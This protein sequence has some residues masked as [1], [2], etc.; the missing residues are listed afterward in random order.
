VCTTAQTPRA[1]PVTIVNTVTTIKT[2]EFSPLKRAALA[3]PTCPLCH[4]EDTT[5]TVQAV[6]EGGTWRCTRCGQMWSAD[7]LAAVAAYADK[8]FGVNAQVS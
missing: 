4:T 8:Q 1:Q 3:T 2:V 6:A 5:I 7:R